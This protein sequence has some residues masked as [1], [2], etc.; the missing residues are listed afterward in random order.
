MWQVWDV[1]DLV[2]QADLMLQAAWDQQNAPLFADVG[3]VGRLQ[4]LEAAVVGLEIVSGK[5]EEATQ[6]AMR[7]LVEDEYIVVSSFV[8]AADT[9]LT[10]M[11]EPNLTW[12]RESKLRTSLE[13]RRMRKAGKNAALDIER[14]F[15]F[16]LELWGGLLQRGSKKVLVLQIDNLPPRRL[17]LKTRKMIRR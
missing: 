9:L 4:Q 17:P 13:F 1:N 8:T 14:C 11:R 16:C 6:L 5:L 15:L 12:S 2:E 10:L 3:R 7:M